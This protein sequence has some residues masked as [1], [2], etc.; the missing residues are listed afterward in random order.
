[1]ATILTKKSD[2]ASSVPLVADLTNAAGGAELAVNTADKRLFTKTSGGTVVELGINPSSM[3]LPNGTANGVPYLNGSKVLTSGSALTFDGTQFKVTGNAAITA[4]SFPALK[5]YDNSSNLKGEIY[6]GVGGSDLNLVNYAAG[7]IIF[8]PN[9][10]EAMHLTSS[11]NL[12]L[13]VTPSAWTTYKALQ[14]GWS[15]LAGYAAADTAVFSNAYFDG[16]YKY[17]G[18]G[19]AS[20]YRQINSAH[21]WF[22]AP[23]GTAGNAISFIQAMT[24]D[25]SGN[26]GVGTTSPSALGL[27]VTKGSGVAAGVLLNNS[28][29]NWSISTG[30]SVNYLA[31]VDNQFS[32]RARID[33]SGNLLVGTTSAS[34]TPSSGISLNVSSNSAGSS[35]IALGH[36]NGSASGDKYAWFNYN[37]STIGSITQNGTTAVAY[38]TT[39][40]HRLKNNVRTADALR[41]KDIRFVDF[42]WVDGR[43]DC[44][45]IAH[46]LQAIYPDLV[47]GTK[48]ETEV[49]T[50]ELTPAVPAVLDEEG[51][52]VTPEVPAVTEEQTFDKHQQVN[53]IGLIPRMGTIVQQLMAKVEA[54]EAEIAALKAHP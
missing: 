27:Q 4:A 32:E 23:S 33:S 52:V 10:T 12:G 22:T 9:N 51:N 43:H 13:G 39:S 40:D 5:Y 45:V 18:N 15:S 19:F 54:M 8:K 14:N 38:N 25:A 30:A 16:G 42:E 53:Y 46:E 47:V 37:G 41:F 17:I 49:R 28:A 36:I 2:T 29:N 1:M 31:F 20:Q 24:L 3:T 44:G 34:N 7:P 21:Q 26:L 50:V 35:A 11:G 6:Y 48:D